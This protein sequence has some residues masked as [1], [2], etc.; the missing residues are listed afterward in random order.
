MKL[1][2]IRK[3]E[4]I[5]SIKLGK[6]IVDDEREKCYKVH[7]ITSSFFHFFYYGGVSVF[8]IIFLFLL[9]PNILGSIVLTFFISIVLYFIIELFILLILPLQ[10]VDCWKRNL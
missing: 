10:E 6:I 8:V 7:R 3:I 5:F 9:L 2:Y 4:D 1:E